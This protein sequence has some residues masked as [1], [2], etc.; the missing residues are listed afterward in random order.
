MPTLVKRLFSFFVILPAVVL[1]VNFDYANYILLNLAV[2]M[3]A[4]L[5]T[6]EVYSILSNK[7]SMQPKPFVFV[8]TLSVP[9]FTAMLILF[10]LPLVLSFTFPIIAFLLS[11]VYE[12]LYTNK[13]NETEYDN[14]LSHILTTTFIVIYSGFLITYIMHISVLNNASIFLAALCLMTYGCDSIAWFF[15]MTM[16]K[17]NRGIFTVSPNKS[18]AGFIGGFVG[19]IIA[20]L[21][22][23]YF[24]PEVF[25]GPVFKIIILAIITAFFA[26]FGDLA[27]S[28]L[29]RF[30]HIKDSGHEVIPGRGGMSDSVDSLIMTA[31]VYYFLI[32][33]MY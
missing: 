19:S 30:G 6:G 2:V 31:P 29:K 1:L 17:N 3:V 22:A 5:V 27:E 12:V 32:T 25:V 21:A 9:F 23:W 18:L 11:L 10:E 7:F 4:F 28:V 8:L 13:K 26:I 20:G 16:G 33:I 15:G 14:A 24:F